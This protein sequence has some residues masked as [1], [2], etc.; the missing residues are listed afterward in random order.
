MA[1]YT[2][3]LA[4]LG[5]IATALEKDDEARASHLVAIAAAAG[6]LTETFLTHTG[7]I[8]TALESANDLAEARNEHLVQHQR[9][10]AELIEATNAD[11]GLIVRF[12]QQLA[13]LGPAPR[14]A[15]V[16]SLIAEARRALG[17]EE[18]PSRIR[19]RLEDLG[20]DIDPSRVRR[21]LEDDEDKPS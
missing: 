17:R 20:T 1:F 19:R 11:G 14:T 5:R 18:T 3:T 16:E 2:D 21:A 9:Q 10:Q 6:K 8:A 13:D 12:V 4:V 15:T 7:R